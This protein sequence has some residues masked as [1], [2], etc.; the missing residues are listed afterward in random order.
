MGDP[1]GRV[2]VQVTG[3]GHERRESGAT[4]LRAWLS[5]AQYLACREGGG[6]AGAVGVGAGG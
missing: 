1:E 5:G 4:R 3:S 2:H 6:G